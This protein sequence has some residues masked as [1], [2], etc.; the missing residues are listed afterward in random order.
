MWLK[1]QGYRVCRFA[2]REVLRQMDAVL[3]AIARECGV[4]T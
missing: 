2:N 1:A 3:E 4:D